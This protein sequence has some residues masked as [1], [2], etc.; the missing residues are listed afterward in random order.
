MHGGNGLKYGTL[1]YPDT[2]Q[3]W[4]DYSYGLVIFL[5]LV[6]FWLS[7]TCQIWSFQAISEKPIEEMA[8]NLHADVSWPLSEL[9]RLW[10]QFVDFSNF[11]AILT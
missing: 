4:L 1:L 2:I 7:E 3:N 6:L 9:I 8:W 11:D 10:L 5:I